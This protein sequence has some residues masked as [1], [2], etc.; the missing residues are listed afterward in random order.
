VPEG[1]SNGNAH[2]D[3]DSGLQSVMLPV[4]KTE[5]GRGKQL[6]DDGRLS[7]N[8]GEFWVAEDDT[9]DA[10]SHGSQQQS[11]TVMVVRN[12]INKVK[13]HEIYIYIFSVWCQLGFVFVFCC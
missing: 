2:G 13:E 9:E 10:A 6:P 7:R 3:H 11:Y 1:G 5:V 12:G 4:G 8:H